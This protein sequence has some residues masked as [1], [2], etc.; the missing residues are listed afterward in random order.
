MAHCFFDVKN[1]AK[2]YAKENNEQKAGEY[3]ILHE[4]INEK[5]FKLIEK[6]G[7]K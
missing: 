5:M 6:G 2:E 3:Y 4:R 1:R 7:F